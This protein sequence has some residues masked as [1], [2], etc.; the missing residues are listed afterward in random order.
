MGQSWDK[1]LESKRAYYEESNAEYNKLNLEA[2]VLKIQE[3]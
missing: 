2:S 3:S 1:A